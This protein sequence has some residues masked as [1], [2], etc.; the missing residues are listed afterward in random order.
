MVYDYIA[1]C[2]QI[3][4][5]SCSSRP[6]RLH[7]LQSVI[8][9]RPLGAW[10]HSLGLFLLQDLCLA[11]VYRTKALKKLSLDVDFSINSGVYVYENVMES[12][13]AQ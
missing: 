1:R 5:I 9:R 2:T 12:T 7:Q 8:R 6:A 3:Q 10:L 4:N 11:N 13:A